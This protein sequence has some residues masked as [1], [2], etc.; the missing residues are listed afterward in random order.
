MSLWRTGTARPTQ[1]QKINRNVVTSMQ[2]IEGESAL[3]QAGEDKQLRVW[4]TRTLRVAQT[5]PPH[6]YIQVGVV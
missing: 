1:S 4:D 5:L 2:F 6:Q 3:L